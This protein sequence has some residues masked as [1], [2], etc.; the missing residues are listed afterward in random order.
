MVS[1]KPALSACVALLLFGGAGIAGAA[2]APK[3]ADS[4]ID[5]PD[6]ITQHAVVLGGKTLPYT[7]HAGTITLYDDKSVAT[8][9]VF[10]TAFTLDGA[11]PVTRPVTFL[12]NG[13]PGSSTMWLRMG[14]FGPVRLLSASAAPSGPPPYRLIDNPYSLLDKTDMVF[15]DMPDS[16]FG[17]ILGGKE[18]DFFGVD[19]DVAAFAQFVQTY[20]SAN[21]RWNSPKFLFGESYGTARSAALADSLLQQGVALNGVVLQSSFLN[22]RLGYGAGDPI[23]AGDWGYVLWLPT[24]AA[25]AWYYGRVADRTENLAAFLSGVKRFALGEYLDALYKGDLLGEGE[26]RD[27]VRKLSAFLGLSPQYVALSNIRVPYQKFQHELLRDRGLV[28]GRIDGRYAT[29]DTDDASYLGPAWDPTDSSIDAP[30]TAAV[31]QYIRVN[32]KYDPPIAY[33]PNIYAII[34]AGDS[35]WDFSHG[36]IFPANMTPDLADAMTQNPSLRIFSANG[37]YDF[38]TPFFGTE[39]ALRHLNVN[40]RLQANISYGYYE[41]GHMMYFTDA[42][43]ARYHDDLERWYDAA[44]GTAR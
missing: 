13:G 10:Y 36:G 1:V 25:T 23:A 44:L 24:E 33:R 19:Q 3:A 43:L 42:A 31:N 7:A 8:A 30:Y 34:Y 28:V 29:A 6:S 2:E 18:K 14:S 4:A 27:V 11:D 17:R 35:T 38:A 39:Y 40:P 15:I 5:Y 37:Y 26:R 22:W 41:T 20:V 12:Y 21:G 16:G 9:R 32:L